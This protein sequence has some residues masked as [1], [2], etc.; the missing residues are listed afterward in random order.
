[1]IL[2]PVSAVLAVG[3]NF[4]LLWFDL[5]KYSPAYQEALK[6][7]YAPPFWQQI[8]YSGLL[9]PVLEELFFRGLVFRLSRKWMPF[10]VS[11]IVSAL[12]FGLYHGNLVQF[13]YAGICGLY[14]AYLYEKYH[15]I[16]VPIF[17]HM[18]MNL[19]ICVGSELRWFEWMLR[20]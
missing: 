15:S 5:P 6:V 11:M 2:F 4:L 14:L 17:A 16:I 19:I 8:F 9:I 10:W 20:A 12:L 3:L 13:V 18:T 1:M 7:L